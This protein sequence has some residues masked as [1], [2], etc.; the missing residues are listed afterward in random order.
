M[1]N[2]PK[3]S[4]VSGGPANRAGKPQAAKPAVKGG[5]PQRGGPRE[6]FG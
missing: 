5:A 4:N 3:Q 2:K 6:A 1:A